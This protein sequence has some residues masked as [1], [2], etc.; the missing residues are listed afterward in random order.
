MTIGNV[1]GAAGF[2]A[3]G[4]L[5]ASPNEAQKAIAAPPAE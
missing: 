1:G 5:G 2:V 4:Y 3:L